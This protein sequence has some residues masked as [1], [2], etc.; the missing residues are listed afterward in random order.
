MKVRLTARVQ[1]LRE[2]LRL[3]KLAG[4]VLKGEDEG[5]A[6]R[7]RSNEQAADLAAEVVEEWL[8]EHT[9]RKPDTNLDDILLIER[10]AGALFEAEGEWRQHTVENRDDYANKFVYQAE[11]VIEELEK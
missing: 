7:F 6:Y 5:F 2:R 3:A 11:A 4:T 1:I 9:I 10:I 8:Q